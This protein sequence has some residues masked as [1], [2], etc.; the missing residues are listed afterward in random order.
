MVWPTVYWLYSAFNSATT[1]N[2]EVPSRA[3][4]VSQ[5]PFVDFELS[6]EY[7]VY[8]PKSPLEDCLIPA[9]QEVYLSEGFGYEHD[10]VNS[11]GMLRGHMIFIDFPDAPHVQ[12]E[13]MEAYYAMLIPDAHDWY[14]KV[15]DGA[16]NFSVTADFSQWYRMKNVSTAYEWQSPTLESRQR[17]LSDAI[18]AWSERNDADVEAVDV[19]HVAATRQATSIWNSPTYMGPRLYTAD[20]QPVATKAIT[21]G[22]DAWYWGYKL[23]THEIGHTMCLPDLYLHQFSR[24]PGLKVGGFDLMGN[25]LG[26]SPQYL[27][28]HRLKLQWINSTTPLQPECIRNTGKYKFWVGTTENHTAVP[29]VIIRL[30][31]TVAMVIEARGAD[32]QSGA[33]GRGVLLYTVSSVIGQGLGPVE[34]LDTRPGSGGCAGNELNDA[35]LTLDLNGEPRSFMSSYWGVKVTAVQ[36]VSSGD[37]NAAWLI[38]VEVPRVKHSAGTRYG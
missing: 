16:L 31:D 19:L 11:T 3:D 5:I 22:A 29:M 15:S 26:I 8:Y 38:E 30:E 34:V 20:G 10:C 23:I 9:V 14:W 21:L 13:S 12:N 33:C 1:A 28:W 7:L 2:S 37:G 24:E 4:L 17:Y 6:T 32:L 25:I 27:Q 18:A 36:E 35:P